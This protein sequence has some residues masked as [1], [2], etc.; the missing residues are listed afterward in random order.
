MP[1]KKGQKTKTTGR[2]RKSTI[3]KL[4]PDDELVW[5]D[6][7]QRL[8]DHFNKE[9]H[10]AKVA[11]SKLVQAGC[12]EWEI[13]QNAYLFCGGDA[14]QM[15][16]LRDSY[17][18]KGLKRRILKAAESLQQASDRIRST[19][20]ILE[21][22]GVIC[23]FTPNLESYIG[24]L[25]RFGKVAFRDLANKRISGRD[26]HLAYLLYLIKSNTGKQ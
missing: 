3:L 24:F 19:E 17:D 13:L 1:S 14:Q 8:R 25:K 16:L 12:D 15:T 23:H 11:L 2:I 7:C 4:K 20:K 21:D 9:D 5:A 22:L 18:F 10:Q 26:Q 6:I